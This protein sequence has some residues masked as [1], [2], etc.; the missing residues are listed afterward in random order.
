MRLSNQIGWIA[1]H[2]SINWVNYRSKVINI[3]FWFPDYL[4]LSNLY[5]GKKYYY[6]LKKLDKYICRKFRRPDKSISQVDF[7]ISFENY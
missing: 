5:I 4:T 7:N 6:F 2:G 1:W 3:D